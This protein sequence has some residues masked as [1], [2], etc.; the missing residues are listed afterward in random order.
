MKRFKICLFGASLA[1]ALAAG[2]ALADDTGDA[3][4]VPTPSPLTALPQWWV[5][6]DPTGNGPRVL[7]NGVQK[8]RRLDVRAGV[9]FAVDVV[10]RNAVTNLVAFTFTFHFDGRYVEFV[11]AKLDLLLTSAGGGAILTPDS[12][13]MSLDAD[14][15]F[16]SAEVY[17]PN[18]LPGD[19]RVTGSGT[20]AR[21]TFKRKDPAGQTGFDVGVAFL[22]AQDGIFP[23]LLPAHVT[24]SFSFLAS[25]ATIFDST[26][27]IGCW[28]V[29]S[30]DDEGDTLPG[31]GICDADHRLGIVKGTLRAAIEE[32]NP[33]IFADRISFRIPDAGMAGGPPWTIRPMSP[34]PALS[35]G[36]IEIDGTDITL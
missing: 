4:T 17:D 20:L 3:I 14:T 21:L 31:D 8:C 6:L 12:G 26:G 15:V 7:G 27:R 24:D 28:V 36:S 29:T 11:G 5:D 1:A 19:V 18:E 16:V 35:S 34:L 23:D 22:Y 25:A 9:P 13:A 33:L 32:A 30:T 2:T 10:L